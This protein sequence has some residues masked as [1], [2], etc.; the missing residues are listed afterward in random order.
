MKFE[1]LKTE[2]AEEAEIT[3]SFELK[4]KNSF[5]ANILDQFTPEQQKEIKEKQRILSSLAY[6]IGKDF[7]I[8]VEL[9][10][11]GAGWH[12][13]FKNNIIRI[14][15]KDLL[16]KP[17]DYLRFVISHEGGHRR[18]SRTDFIPLEIWRQNGFSF[19]MNAIEDPRDNN[20]VAAN[21]PRFAEQ[22]KLAYELLLKQE[23]E[24]KEK[25]KGKLG[26]QLRFKQAGWEFIKLWYKERMKKKVEISADLPEEIKKIIKKTLVPASDAWK[27]YPT[28]E[29]AD[30]GGVLPNGERVNGEEMI[31]EYAKQAYEII[32]EEIWPDFQKLV[33]KDL[34]DQKMS[35]LLKD[36]Q[37]EQQKGEKSDEGKGG[38]KSKESGEKGGDGIP[39]EL[40]EK[41]TPEEQKEL[42]K[43]IEKAIEEAKKPADA[44][45]SSGE[46][47]E[48]QE[49][50]KGEPKAVDMDSLS[51]EL[52][53]KIQDYLDSLPEEKKK[54][55]TEKARKALEDFEKETNKEMEGKL[56]ENPEEREEREERE[57]VREEAEKRER[58]KDKEKTGEEVE[59]ER[60]EKKQEEQRRKTEQD[61]REML[62]RVRKSLE[63][64]ENEYQK[65]MKRLAPQIIFLREKL[66]EIF[67][68]RRKRGIKTGF[69]EGEEIDVERRLQEKAKG[70]S[71]FESR[72]WRRTELPKEKDYAITLLVD[73]S[74]SMQGENI[75][76]AFEATVLFTEVLNSLGIK[77]E[78]LG[79]NICLYEY[80]KFADRLSGDVRKRIITMKNQVNLPGNEDNDDGWA[81]TETAK[82][83][84]ARKEKE[85]L[86]LV[87]SDGVPDNS[88]AHNSPEYELGTVIEKIMRE[89]EIKIVGL[90]LGSAG[91]SAVKQFYPEYLLANSAEQMIEKIG[92]LL[93]KVIKG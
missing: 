88:P 57:R 64:Q 87:I 7:Q 24:E 45:E 17:M 4:K 52:K 49:E 6:F 84:K 79:F 92:D 78:V 9:N 20:F 8:P 34:E 60:E 72:A 13:D 70:I 40:K 93:L 5:D 15:P 73:L 14:D 83:L 43:A 56:T 27:T 2:G 36:F 82:R 89:G 28:K 38:E 10:E 53:K 22:M 74:S 48:G 62:E 54:E 58:E 16:E 29:L 55:L 91:V 46:A 65:E 26:H 33:E 80:Q 47:K 37:K 30:R 39:K 71:I 86:L 31:R 35:E 85:K 12:W 21:Y 42:E 67:Q 23:Q 25:A 68:E 69:E 59:K 81:V 90:G 19:L 50:G 32:L 3:S 77:I 66:A 61:S 76:E 44:S 11:P 63:G 18:I 41:L 75:R 51:P 1:E